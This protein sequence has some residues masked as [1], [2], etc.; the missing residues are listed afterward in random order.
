MAL[1]MQDFAPPDTSSDRVVGS[2]LYNRLLWIGIAI[3]CL[4]LAHAAWR[5]ADDA[6][7]FKYLVKRVARKHGFGA[8]FMAKPFG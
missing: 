2:A 6:L 4:A 1:D 7:C 5:A 3:L 8:T